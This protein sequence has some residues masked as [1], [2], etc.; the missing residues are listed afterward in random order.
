MFI[1]V[2]GCGFA[3]TGGSASETSGFFSGVWH[4]LLAPWSLIL[5]AFMDIKMYEFP[6][7]GWPY[8]FGFL[9][10]IVFSIPVGWIAVIIALVA[11]A[12]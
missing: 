1:F 6:N 4:G 3:T 5:R 9:L 12:F 10:G 11:H 7:S 8:D 2:A